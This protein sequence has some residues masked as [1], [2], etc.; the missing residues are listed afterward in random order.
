MK[1]PPCHPELTKARAHGAHRRALLAARRPTG[2]VGIL[3]AAGEKVMLEVISHPRPDFKDP[4]TATT[5]WQ[6]KDGAHRIVVLSGLRFA[7]DGLATVPAGVDPGVDYRTRVKAA[8]AAFSRAAVRHEVG[9]ARFTCR[10]SARVVGEL[11]RVGAPFRLF[12]LFEDV[13]IESHERRDRGPFRWT[14]AQKVPAE[15]ADPRAWVWAAKTAEIGLAA[16]R[17]AKFP[18]WAGPDR[19]ATGD[20]AGAVLARLH[21]TAQCADADRDAGGVQGAAGRPSGWGP[22]GDRKGRWYARR[23]MQSQTSAA[24]FTALSN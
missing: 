12:N 13:R 22:V 21:G 10:D 24:A 14:K 4:E 1:T 17:G 19:T 9:H 6:F 11:R 20:P 16:P 7:A 18:M 23:A 8:Y 15:T 3:R 2:P 5:C